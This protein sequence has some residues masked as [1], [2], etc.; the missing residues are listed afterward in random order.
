VDGDYPRIPY[1]TTSIIRGIAAGN[2]RAGLSSSA[3]ATRNML[4][5][6]GFS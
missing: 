4:F 6:F 3:I 1:N 5:I 2:D